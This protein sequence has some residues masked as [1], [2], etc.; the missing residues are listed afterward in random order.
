MKETL[1]HPDGAYFVPGGTASESGQSEAASTVTSNPEGPHMYLNSVIFS[2]DKGDQSRGHYQQTVPMKWAHPEPSQLQQ[3][4]AA[5]WTMPNWGPAFANY[6]RTQN[7]FVKPM[8]ETSGGL[9]PHQ[10]PT[11][12]AAEESTAPA[13]PK[14]QEP[15]I[16]DITPEPQ[17]PSDPLQAPPPPEPPSQS[18]TQLQ[19]Q[20]QLRRSRRLSKEGGAPSDNPFLSVCSD[21]SGPENGARDV[22]G[23]PTGVIQSTRRKRRVS[24]EV[25]LEMLAQEASERK[26]PSLSLPYGQNLE[27]S[28]ALHSRALL[29]SIN[30]L[31]EQLW[32]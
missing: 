16:Q 28:E 29:Q 26:S 12:R 11:N 27:Q 23:A 1:Q 32:V 15:V 31:Y 10:Q 8:H 30:V 13:P 24:Q 6:T 4:R 3:Q 18:Q 9:Q 22:Q 19:S 17:Q 5:S 20:G 21:Q 7:A 14:I 2:P 25:N